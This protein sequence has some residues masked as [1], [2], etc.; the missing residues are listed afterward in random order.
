MKDRY[1]CSDGTILNLRFNIELEKP[2]KIEGI[3]V[4]A[5]FNRHE[6]LFFD[7]KNNHYTASVRNNITVNTNFK[8]VV[9]IQ[10]TQLVVY[11]SIY[12]K[13]VP[14]PNVVLPIV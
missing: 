4:N 14:M 9:I 3:F 13:Y 11:T 12:A 7:D 5:K 10:G 8:A 6:V 2:S 1:V